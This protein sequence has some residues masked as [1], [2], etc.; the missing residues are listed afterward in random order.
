MKAL[1]LT[2]ARG[3]MFLVTL[4]LIFSKWARFQGKNQAATIN[5]EHLPANMSKTKNLGK[6][7]LAANDEHLHTAQI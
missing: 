2:G 3:L 1:G 6:T 5:D 7:V 4:T